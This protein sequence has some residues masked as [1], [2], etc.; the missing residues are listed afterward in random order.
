MAALEF[1]EA[2][3]P[4]G[5]RV[6]AEINQEAKSLAMGYFIKTGSRDELVGEEGISHFLEH[7]VFKGTK[8]RSAWD[9]NRE[10][11]EMGAKYNAFTNEE[12]TVFYGAVLP[13]F[14]PRLLELLTDLMRPAIREEDFETERKVILEEI[15]LY[16]DRP[17]FILYEKAQAAYFGSHPLAKPV[18]GSVESVQNLTR[19][20]M[21]DYHARRYVPGNMTLAFAGNLD[22][23][24]ILSL[25]EAM[26][27]KW[28]AG[29]AIRNHPPFEPKPARLRDVSEKAAQTYTTFL[30][31][32]VSA[33]SE[34]RYAAR[35]LSE[36]IG[37]SDNSRLYW[38]IVDKGLA[39]TATAFHHEFDE[40]GL[41]YV[42][43]QGDPKNDELVSQAIHEQLEKLEREGVA[44][45]EL[46]RAKLKTATS[47][48]F[49]GETPLSR[50]FYL[51]MTYTYTSRY[52]PLT[53]LRRWVLHLQSY[54]LNELLEAKP[55][56]KALEYHLVPA[57]EE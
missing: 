18:L 46:N 11:G 25:V 40:L 51:G 1:K 54:H 37:D 41:F 12:L 3:L 39:E 43:A 56:S 42:Y 53:A 47:L 16:H 20:Q 13:E 6:I 34:E 26:T 33:S 23:Q 15:A 50:L 32:G 9:V 19:Q 14:A 2:T 52:E 21:V 7:M 35:V 27:A 22:W 38:Q 55:F 28:P 10:F 31:P 48:V 49:A 36:I 29:R 45:E 4:N 57:D 5:L 44:S 24:E 8:K 30:A 17:N